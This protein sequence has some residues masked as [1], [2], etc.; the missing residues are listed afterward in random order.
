MPDPI[1]VRDVVRK[2]RLELD[3]DERAYRI[4]YDVL[5]PDGPIR[6]MPDGLVEWFSHGEPRT[7]RVV[8]TTLGQVRAGERV[9]VRLDDT[10]DQWWLCDVE[11]ATEPSGVEGG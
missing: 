2:R 7:S 6:L 8:A 3:S 10:P 11:A 4:S 9:L 1:R 5:F